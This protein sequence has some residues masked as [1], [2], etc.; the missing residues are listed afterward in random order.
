MLFK[1]KVDK[2]FLL[3]IVLL[4]PRTSSG[5]RSHGD[6]DGFFENI[7]DIFEN[8]GAV[9]VKLFVDKE[10]N[11]WKDVRINLAVL[12]TSGT[13][14]SSF[15]NTVLG[16][17]ADDEG[18]AAVGVKETTENISEYPHPQYP[19]L[20][21]WDLPGVGTPNF[22]RE[23]YSKKVNLYR[24][25]YFIF[26]TSD[27]FRDDDVWLAKQVNALGKLFYFVRNKVGQDIR[28]NKYDH[29]KSHSDAAVLDDIR[30]NCEH[31]LQ[32]L[33]L[34]RKIQIYLTDLHEPEKYDFE[35]LMDQVISDAPEY[36]KEAI[37]LSMTHLT[38]TL[39]DRKKEIL[40]ERIHYMSL[41]SGLTGAIPVPILDSAVD[42]GILTE[43]AMFYR[44]QLGLRDEMLEAF[45]EKSQMT[46]EQLTNNLDLQ[47]RII[48]L[49]AKGL[50]S[51]FTKKGMKKAS[52]FT[53]AK[54]IK[55]L[56]P[57]FG[58]AVSGAASYAM[59]SWC[60]QDLLDVMVQD[61]IKINEYKMHW[62]N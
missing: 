5:S 38:N 60:L 35:K 43:E 57:L 6:S 30:H 34:D 3:V 49:S 59:T 9:A 53:S 48:G 46:I 42:I 23:N 55:Y 40:S 26:M 8:G 18:S 29:P 19:N 36:K 41:L 22:N 37:I 54:F 12:G 62:N 31:N 28:N 39:I 1:A 24:F 47:S 52:T 10:L 58:N 21:L 17:T 32:K 11:E 44:A 27:R 50:V 16:L 2:T 25:D 7:K 20:V 45:A 56:L 61:A 4:V 33:N 51:Y 15:I 14:K 13:G